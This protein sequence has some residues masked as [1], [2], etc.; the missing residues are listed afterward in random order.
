MPGGAT[1]AA[2]NK[3]DF[4]AGILFIFFGAV[5]G[6]QCLGEGG[7]VAKT[8]ADALADFFFD[9]GFGHLVTRRF[10]FMDD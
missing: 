1:M 3:A 6:L 2:I 7:A 8:F 5:F 4:S 9:D 10:E